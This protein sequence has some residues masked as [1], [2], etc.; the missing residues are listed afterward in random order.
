MLCSFTSGVWVALLKYYSALV[1]LHKNIFLHIISLCQVKVSEL[2]TLRKSF[3]CGYYFYFYGA[4]YHNSQFL[5][6]INQTPSSD[7]HI[8]SRMALSIIIDG[9]STIYI[10]INIT[11]IIYFYDQRQISSLSHIP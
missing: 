5:R 6:L 3:P 9:M 10:Y 8:E 4:I 11:I 2:G 7:H 1:I